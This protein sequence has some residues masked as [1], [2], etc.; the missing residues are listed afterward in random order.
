MLSKFRV[1]IILM[2]LTTVTFAQSVITV[3][4]ADIAPGATVNWTGNSTYLLDGFVFV[5]EGAVLNIE[6]G[7]V[8]KGKAT[9]TTGDNASAL[10]ISRG[11]Q[12]FAEGTKDNPIIFTAESD[13]IFNPFDLTSA[14]RG[15]WGGLIILGRADINTTSG[16]GQVEGIPTTEPRAAYGGGDTPDDAESSGVLR[17]VSIRHGGAEL[18]PGDEING[19]T[20][21]AVGSGTTVEYVEIYSNLDDAVEWFG[22]TV[23]TKYLVSA[24]CG[25]DGFDFD[26]GWRGKNQFWFVLQGED[27]AGRMAEQDGGTSPEDGLPYAIPQI[28]N[29]TYIGSGITAFPQGDGSE[30]LIFRDNAGGKYYNSIIT[31]YNGGGGGA[32]ITVEDLESGEDSRARLEGGDL[33]LSN[34]IWWNFGDGNDV[35]NIAPQD[36]VRTHFEANNNQI[37]DPQINSISRTGDGN[38]DPRPDPSGPAGSGAVAP[39]DPFFTTT[40]YYGAFDPDGLLWIGGWTSLSHNRI[41]D[42]KVDKITAVIPTE[43]ILTQNYPNPFNPATKINFSLPKDSDV[44]LTVYNILGQQVEVLVNGFRNAGTYELTWDASNLPSG[45]YIYRLET[46]SNVISKK[47]MLLK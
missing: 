22:G 37:I 1:I 5:E 38:L 36:F 24:F 9:P 32:G 31:E 17:Y 18:S 6:A 15:L 20:L 29:A 2:T 39:T 35:A 46:G 26:E 10:I 40:S 27:F 19:L 47:M 28:Y 8:I 45:V 41:T 13:D 4:D 11:A 7:T 23:N 16:V 25:D 33:V 3:T 43:Y 14:D 44:E 42:I 30:A 12:I 34:N 21:G